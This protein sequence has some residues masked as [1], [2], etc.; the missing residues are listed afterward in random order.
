MRIFLHTLL[1]NLLVVLMA[2]SL[3]AQ[4][5]PV[6]GLSVNIT[7]RMTIAAGTT[8]KITE[9][10]LL[11]KSD[12]TGDASLI[13]FG[14]FEFGQEGQASVQ[15][16]FP[17]SPLDWILLGAPV[18]EMS[19][20]GSEF[21]PRHEEGTDNRI[22]D[23]Y[24]WHE[25]GWWLNYK[26]GDGGGFGTYNSGF[27]FIPGRAY[28]VAYDFEAGSNP[29]KTFAGNLNIGDISF[30]LAYGSAEPG[31]KQAKSYEHQEGY[32]LFGN[33]YTSGIDWNKADRTS[34]QDDYAYVYSRESNEDG[35]TEGYIPVD[36]NEAD[37]FIAP[38]QGF[39]VLAKPEADN[40]SFIFKDIMQAHGGEFTKDRP[41]ASGSL[42]LRL[43]NEHYYDETIISCRTNSDFSRD[44]SDAM[45][46]FSYNVA[47]PQVYSM[48][49]D[50]YR[51]AINAI[52]TTTE[53]P[54]IKVGIKTPAQGRYSLAL[55]DMEGVFETKD[56][57]LADLVQDNEILLSNDSLYT[58]DAQAS[59]DDPGILRFELRFGKDE[60]T[61]IDDPGSPHNISDNIWNHRNTLY[62][63]SQEKG[64]VIGVYDINGR[65]LRTY[66]A[67]AGEQSYYMDLPAGIYVVRMNKSSSLQTKKIIVR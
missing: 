47:M 3:T 1:L 63:F 42:T 50:G 56:I 57:Y 52:P 25:S 24:M 12:D 60:E 38:H 20:K 4:Q 33:P 10:D 51:T 27:D 65:K 22:D 55:T 31:T 14:S 34:F 5:D 16:Y 35:S 39:M 46:L 8:I 66:Q 21:E 2:A 6:K 26:T 19:I 48:T 28:L 67:E 23:F 40:T 64:A 7:T 53:G 13:V 41:V 15:R 43:S 29:T 32:N 45:K 49:S 37:A 18:A 17:G 62:I 44:R 11:L 30:T 58:F 54:N 59:G 36:G 9:G 61:G